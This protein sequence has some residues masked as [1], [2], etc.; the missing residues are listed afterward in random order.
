MGNLGEITEIINATKVHLDLGANRYI[1]LQELKFHT[2]RPESR[3]STDASSSI[4]TDSMT[5]ILLQQ[6]CYLVQKFQFLSI[7]PY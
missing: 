3:E 7:I 5:I 2:G 4:F 6:F 1:L